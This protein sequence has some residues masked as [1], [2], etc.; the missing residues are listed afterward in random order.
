M[1]DP[2]LFEDGPCNCGSTVTG[3]VVNEDD[4]VPVLRIGRCGDISH[5]PLNDRLFI[6]GWNDD[7]DGGKRSQLRR[8]VSLFPELYPQNI[9]DIGN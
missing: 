1:L 8:I 2:E 4:L 3:V 6:Q 5:S 9:D 7:A